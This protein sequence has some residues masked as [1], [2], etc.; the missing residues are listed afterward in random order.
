MRMEEK[1]KMATVGKKQLT[2]DRFFE[3][4]EASTSANVHL[5]DDRDDDGDKEVDAEAAALTRR[6]LRSRPKASEASVASAGERRARPSTSARKDVKSDESDDDDGDKEV[7]AEVAALMRRQLRPRFKASEASGAS[8]GKRGARP[9]TSPHEDVQS[10]DD[11]EYPESDGYSSEEWVQSD[12]GES[13]SDSIS[14]AEDVEDRGSCSQRRLTAKTT[15]RDFFQ[16]QLRVTLLRV[17]RIKIHQPVDPRKN[18]PKNLAGMK[19]AGSQ[20]HSPLL[21]SQVPQQS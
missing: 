11:E 1:G 17:S 7:D 15:K 4:G 5:Y 13:D 6:Q 12:H 21:R 16:L 14:S 20:T 8:A 2:L 3:K 19:Q 18:I 10:D 9:S